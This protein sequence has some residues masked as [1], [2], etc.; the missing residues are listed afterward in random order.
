MIFAQQWDQSMAPSMLRGLSLTVLAATALSAPLSSSS[1]VQE[2]T[3]AGKRGVVYTSSS[4]ANLFESYPQI[5][6]GYNWGYPSNGLSAQVS[7]LRVH[8][9]PA[10]GF[11]NSNFEYVPML[12]GDPSGNPSYISDWQSNAAAA[13]Q[14]GSKHL[15]AF[16]EPD[17]NGLS[18][19]Q[20]AASYQHYIQPLASS[21]VKLGAPAVTNGGAPTGLTWLGEFL[22]NCTQCTIDFVP[23]HWYCGYDNIG[24]FT[25]YVQEAYAAGG[26]RPLWITEFQGNDASC[27]QTATDAQQ[28]EFMETVLP[29]LD[30]LDYVERYAYF[31]AVENSGSNVYLVNDDGTTLT[32]NGQTYA[33]L[34]TV[35]STMPTSLVS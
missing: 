2:R 3:V 24:Y 29:W 19:A 8:R 23:F 10:D 6:W 20:A 12:W 28:V 1:P 25:S 9:D 4:L 16:N 11:R 34:E 14:S 15:L 13:I 32:Y 35:N 27:G 26:N 31:G 5:T 18:P 7:P 21:T 17:V 30:S 22:G 33:T